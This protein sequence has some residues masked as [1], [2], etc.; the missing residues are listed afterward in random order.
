MLLDPAEM[1]VTTWIP[2]KWEQKYWMIDVASALLV[3]D[4]DKLYDVPTKLGLSTKSIYW[5]L[6]N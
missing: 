2:I 1:G 5:Y 3:T 6:P 4:N